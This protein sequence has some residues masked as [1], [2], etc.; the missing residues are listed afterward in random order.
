VVS[1]LRP[2]TCED[3]QWRITILDRKKFEDSIK[4]TLKEMSE[5][6]RKIADCVYG[7]E[8][9]VSALNNQNTVLMERLNQE[10]HH[11][12][13][14]YGSGSF[15][16]NRSYMATRQAKIDFPRFDGSNLNGWLF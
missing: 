15:Q 2:H 1:E 10:V 6:I 14:S 16:S 11:G 12:G 9:H 7:Q 5:N 3:Y 8:T 13:S 4:E